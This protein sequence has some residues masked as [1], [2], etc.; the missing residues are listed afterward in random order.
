MAQPNTEQEYLVE[1]Q[2]HMDAAAEA[3]QTELEEQEAKEKGYCLHCGDDLDK[4]TGYKCW[5][6]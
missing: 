4:C 3:H 6:R 1:Q 5:I 2:A